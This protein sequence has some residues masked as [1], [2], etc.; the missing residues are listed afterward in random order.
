MENNH[1]SQYNHL[2]LAQRSKQAKKKYS[3]GV[4]ELEEITKR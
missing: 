1:Q 4:A 2:N 3:K